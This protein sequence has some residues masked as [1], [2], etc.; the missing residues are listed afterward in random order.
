ME[1]II[2]YGVPS[3][4]SLASVIA[5]EWLGQP[6][7]LVRIE[8][9]DKWPQQ[10]AQV[11]PRMKTPAMLTAHG[12]SLT[13]SLAILQHIGQ[14]GAA[15]GLGFAPGTPDA[16]RL[17]S[18]LSY[19]VTDLFAAFAPLWKL[20]D[21][22]I[23]DPAVKPVLRKY[24]EDSV[25]AEYAYLDQLLDGRNWLLGGTR[26]TVADAYLFAIGRWA[27]YHKVL[28]LEEGYPN[29]ARYMRKL[30][31]DPAVRF[32]LDIEANGTAHSSG[33]FRGH[34]SITQLDMSKASFTSTLAAA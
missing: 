18:M 12:D 22:G 15:T 7:H 30:A 4:C 13:E 25:R 32:A 33:G 8:M 17:A 11:N 23:D 5:S 29:L 16:D 10:F 31:Q 19:L 1:P 20:Y 34:L 6:Y 27:E 9:M 3:G 2:F 26:P 24:G 21:A 28:T 14:R